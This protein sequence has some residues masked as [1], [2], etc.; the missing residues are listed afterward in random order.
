V[1]LFD[2]VILKKERFYEKEK[3]LEKSYRVYRGACSLD[4]SIHV[5]ATPS[6]YIDMER[7]VLQFLGT[8]F[9]IGK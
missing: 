4:G 6:I 2:N 5:R 8:N 1:A 3:S 7:K 9:L